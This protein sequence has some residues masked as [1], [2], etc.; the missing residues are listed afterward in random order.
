MTA[1]ITTIGGLPLPT[2]GEPNLDIVLALEELLQLARQG[3]LV[4]VQLF[5]QRFDGRNHINSAGPFDIE[6]MIGFM[7]R[8][9]H[10]LLIEATALGGGP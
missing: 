6:L 4:G 8:R 2:P 5:A 10:E 7:E 9:K 1:K 3:M